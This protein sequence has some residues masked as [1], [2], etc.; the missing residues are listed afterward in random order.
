MKLLLAFIPLFALTACIGSGENS[1]VQSQGDNTIPQMVGKDLM[2]D[3]R[4]IPNSFEGNLNIVTFAFERE[5]QENV[6]TW[7]PHAEAMEQE[8]RSVRFYEIPLIYEMNAFMRGWVNNGMRSGIPSE[9]ARE[10]TITV[11]TDRDKFLD[12]MNMQTDSI[13]TLLVNKDGKILWRASGDATDEKIAALRK[14]I[15][16]S[17]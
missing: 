14:A 10:R 17:N 1:D 13:Y 9:K 16:R 6:N 11:Y 3:D 15:H 7:I 5:Q 12:M 4:P 8:F 2:G